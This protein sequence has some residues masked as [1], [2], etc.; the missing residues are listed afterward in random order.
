LIAYLDS[1]VLLRVVLR[2]PAQLAEWDAINVAVCSALVR[3]ECARTLDRLWRTHAMTDEEFISKRAK[4]AEYLA[5]PEMMPVDD[6]VLGRASTSFP[7]HL[8]TLDAIH[9]A[10]ALLYREQTR[11]EHQI[12]FATHDLALARAARAMHFDVVGV[13]ALTQRGNSNA[14]PTMVGSTERSRYSH[15]ASA[16][17]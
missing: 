13:A 11:N 2:Q 5:L 16:S 15:T 1:S 17:G 10:T 14:R 12:V 6:R 9:L 8:R 3:V 4:V 7:T